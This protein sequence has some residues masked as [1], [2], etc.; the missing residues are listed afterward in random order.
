MRLAHLITAFCPFLLLAPAVSAD[1]VV[2]PDGLNIE[3]ATT[4][5]QVVARLS[6]GDLLIK[7]GG[8]GPNV[9]RIRHAGNGL[10]TY[11]PVFDSFSGTAQAPN[12]DL[13]V[14]NFG[15]TVL[16]IAR[17]G[18]TDGDALDGGEWF[19]APISLAVLPPVS[20]G[21][22][23]G[24]FAPYDM[25]FAP[26]TDDLYIAGSNFSAFDGITWVVRILDATEPGAT[27]E[28]Y[29]STS[30]FTGGIAFHDGALYLGVFGAFPD[31]SRVEKLVDGGADGAGPTVHVYAT[32]LSGA[33]HLAFAADGTGF[34]SGTSDPGD[35]SATVTR[36]AP[37]GDADDA[38]DA[39]DESF[40]TGIDFTAGFDFTGL[41]VLDEGLGGFGPGAGRNSR[42]YVGNSEI[43]EGGY[44]VRTAPPASTEV[45]GTVANN[46]SFDVTVAGA[47]FAL[48]LHVLTLDQTPS[49][50]P[51]IGDIC[52]GFGGPHVVTPLVS[53]G[54]AGE[55][56]T[57]YG[58]HG[59]GALVGV[60]MTI[61]GFTFEAGEIGIGNALNFVI[62]G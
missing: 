52:V 47:P 8:F 59:V 41:L 26:G 43:L 61:Q 25:E 46:D 16:W 4:G 28:V 50:L 55:A 57:S 14:G 21:D 31:P 60:G 34:L 42:L 17:D 62:G 18:N 40:L 45:T 19:P 13:F 23:N 37:D 9:L 38:A 5:G 12:G 58:L 27:A 7:G 54:G 53:L 33:N 35:F 22:P 56:T 30:G 39:V 1:E 6:S 29:H 49:T 11:T 51:G 32:G 2:V 15:P 36:L 20:K 24:Q 10:T 3:T 44:T 48:S